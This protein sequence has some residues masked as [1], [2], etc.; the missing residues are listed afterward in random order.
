MRKALIG[1]ACVVL[2]CGGRPTG[3]APA[4]AA[5]PDTA[6]TTVAAPT[7]RAEQRALFIAAEQALA[8]GDPVS[9]RAR[10]AALASGYGDLDD[11]VLDGQAR[12]SAAAGDEAAAL[13]AWTRLVDTAP[14][15]LLLPRAELARGRLLAARGDDARASAALTRARDD[16]DDATRMAA[17]LA[18][19]AIAE[20][21]GDADGAYAAFM[22]ARRTAPGTP[23]ARDAKQRAL[24]LRARHAD[25]A[26][27]GE[28]LERELRLDL[29]E[30]DFNGARA[31]A[32]TLLASA[33]SPRLLRARADAERGA[34]AFDESLATLREI[35]RRYPQSP[36]AAA[37]QL[38]LATLLWNRDRN[39]EAAAEF[40]GYLARYPGAAGAPE[41]LYALARID[42]GEGREEAAIAAYRRLLATA[43]GA[44]QA[45]DARWRI[46]WIRYQ[47]GRWADAVDAFE[48]AAGGRGPA[49]DPEA[50]YWAARARERGGDGAAA[51]RGY[52]ALLAAAPASYYAGLAEQR[53]GRASPAPKPPAA[54]APL[55]VPAAPAGADV[56]HW[57]R[58]RELQ[59]IGRHPDARRE[60]R[61]VERADGGSAAVA[62]ALPRAYQAVGG[63]RDAIR[64]ATA[65]GASDP[66]LLYPLGFWPTVSRQS[67]AQNV[68]P[69]LVT[70][71]T[72][73]E[74]LFDP[75]AR[76]PADARGLM[77][78]LP[79]TAERVARG[80]GEASPVDHLYD[81]EVNVALG[82]AYLGELL[83]LYGGDPIRACAAYNGGEPA[84]ARWQ[85]RFGHL[86]PDEFVESITFRETRDYVKKVLGNRRRYQQLYAAP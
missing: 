59:A 61:A 8:A 50:S 33:P 52:A 53:L 23:L 28:A 70:A 72:R 36:D 35:S 26:P 22:A 77:Q 13:A 44:P 83:R 64:L 24:A 21:R 39:A 34:G 40:R 46:G 62:A 76:S 51:A 1:L 65:R 73:Q 75:E 66:T 45:R 67:A 63:Y 37:A 12:A 31:A 10:F 74:S 11:Y 20:R 15:S 41:A 9:A 7:T 6:A 47:Q 57:T 60:L 38:R 25:L 86:P 81:P 78:L 4:P 80:R 48:Q 49:A 58:A 43:P 68:D 54:P 17:N 2:G 32:D 30:G 3:P 14:R 69:L 56:Y 5:A 82:T 71:L 18:L 79:S 16:G 85:E 19:G 55:D 27:R 84:V 29:A 42:Q